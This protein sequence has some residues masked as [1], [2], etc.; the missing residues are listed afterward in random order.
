[1]LVRELMD[2]L[3]DDGWKIKKSH[4]HTKTG[5][6]QASIQMVSFPYVADMISRGSWMPPCIDV[7]DL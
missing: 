6:F 4:P 1:M 7:V 2:D 3:L 5:V